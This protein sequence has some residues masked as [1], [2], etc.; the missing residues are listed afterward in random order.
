MKPH[1]WPVFLVIVAAIGGLVYADHNATAAS[2][3]DTVAAQGLMPVASTPHA[4]S[5]SFYCA[6]GTASQNGAF[7]S[8]IVIA[9]PNPTQISSTITVYPAAA[10]GDT[11]G[12]TAVAALKPVTK[13]V[14][15]NPRTRLGV[16]LATLQASPYAAALVETNDP[17]V[18]VEHTIVSKQGV[19]ASPCASAPSPNWYFPTGTT[20]RDAHELLAIFNPFSA[21]AVVDVTF[22]TNDGFRAP[23]GD[24]G[25]PI[26]AGHLRIVDVT[27]DVPRLEQLAAFV[28][29]RAGQVIVDRLQSFDGTDPNHPG[30]TASTLGGP[31]PASVWTFAH[32]QVTDSVHET[33]TLL[34]PGTEPEQV[35][36]EIALDNPATNGVVDPI[37]VTVPPRGY[38]QVAMQDQTRVP[39]AVGHS[40]TVRSISGPGVVAERVVRATVPSGKQ[41][42]APAIGAPLQ[43]TQWLFADGSAIRNSSDVYLAVFNPSPDQVA[44]VSVT[45]LAQGQLLPLDGA[46]NVDVPAGGRVTLDLGKS[47]TRPDLTVI[48]Q[49]TLPVVVERNY[50][51]NGG[52]SFAAGMPM[53]G[54]A[55]VPARAAPTTTTSTTAPA[56]N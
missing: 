36:L 38:T 54:T 20:T 48:A 55:S 46:Q 3:A 13:Q 51:V 32:G 7:D 53:S 35:Q 9:N 11:A 40:V 44:R 45:A 33:I 49:T 8:T 12:Q 52:L 30:G 39:K 47:V 19:N 25:L 1:R 42:F 37:P 43:A 15:V 4:V 24:Q 2:Q 50:F 31:Q 18:A 21:D 56:P 26:P 6:G 41:G 16:R 10:P 17:D 34:N 29:A 22:Q 27:A 23:D 5:S 28:D 14:I